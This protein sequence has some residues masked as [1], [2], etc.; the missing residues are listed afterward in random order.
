MKT[1]TLYQHVTLPHKIPQKLLIASHKN[2]TMREQNI[3]QIKTDKRRFDSK[4]CLRIVQLAAHKS[5]LGLELLNL[6][7]QTTNRTKQSVFLGTLGQKIYSLQSKRQQFPNVRFSLPD[8]HA[9]I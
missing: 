8:R 3:P 9:D 2:R 7:V 5:Q 6:T 4:N 1:P